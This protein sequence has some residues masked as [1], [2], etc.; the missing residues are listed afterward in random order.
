[1]AR[2]GSIGTQYFDNS[3]DPLINGELYFYE[4]GTTTDKP[5]YQD[6][7]QTVAHAQP[8]L[9]DAAGRQPNIFFDGAAKCV[10]ETS[11][12]VQIEVRDPVP[13][14]STAQDAFADWNALTDYDEGAL[15]K[16]SDDL[17]YKSI[18]AANLNN[19][20][21]TSSGY[22]QLVGFVNTYD[23]VQDYFVDQIAVDSGVLYVCIQDGTGQTPASSPT[24]WT[25][26]NI[27]ITGLTSDIGF[28]KADPAVLGN[29]TDGT[30]TVTAN[31]TSL[32]AMVKLYGDTH[33]TKAGDFEFLDDTTVVAH[34]DASGS[35]FDFQANA[36][37]TTGVITGGASIFA[38]GTT[39]GNL[40][41][42]DGSIVDSSGAI[43]FGDENLVTT[44]TLGSAAFTS[45]GLVTGS[46]FVGASGATITAFLDDDSF[47]T[48]SATT[49]ATS[50]SIKAYVDAQVGTA[51]TLAEVLAL[52]NTSGA[53]NLIIDSGQVITTNTI[54]ETTAASGV[55]I[56]SVLLKDNTVLAGTALLGA[57][58]LTDSSGA[59]SF[60]NENLS[61]TGTL[62]SG[63]LTVTGGMSATDD[64]SWGVP[65]TIFI[66]NGAE[67]VFNHPY[68]DSAR[69]II[70][71]LHTDDSAQPPRY[72]LCKNRGGP[73]SHQTVLDGDSLG[74]VQFFGDDGTNFVFA[75]MIDMSVSGTPSTGVVPTKMILQTATTAGAVV[76]GIEIDNAQNV[77]IPNGDLTVTAGSPS[78]I[79]STFA[80]GTTARAY[81]TLD[82]EST[83]GTPILTMT[84]AT[85][86]WINATTAS[87]TA[88]ALNIQTGGTTGLSIDLSQNVSIPNG[89]LTFDGS[90]YLDTWT[91]T[92]A[93]VVTMTAGSSGTITMN[94][95]A[96]TLGYELHGDLCHVQ[97][98]LAVSSV[99]SPVGDWRVSLPFTAANLAEGLGY[100][101]GTALAY[102]YASSLSGI[103]SILSGNGA[104]Y[105]NIVDQSSAGVVNSEA[106]H[107]GAGT[108]VYLDF[109]YRIA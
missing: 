58:S 63:A 6:I 74:E 14:A 105:F 13:N 9:L 78:T 96:D 87:N 107:V 50:E 65:Q 25:S 62:A 3:G 92:T 102:N 12:S 30:M 52:G 79:T 19:N 93:Y 69:N 43:S 15:V 51:D 31:T 8:V 56:D 99:S 24:Y 59:I 27:N 54:S 70:V 91:N 2:F 49:A 42:A 47:G 97:G 81:A 39:V 68:S 16:G 21:V 46:S 85:S 90:N 26:L 104:T 7:N 10:L 100:G 82:L 20:P 45:S 72:R 73:D 22:W 32:G 41:L 80:A 37:S 34:Y 98:W 55:T 75:G 106:N 5:V 88:T 4:S 83:T 94:T 23:A 66:G 95:G 35:L 64:S 101:T 84:G 61:T 103:S 44:G 33:A 11:A 67:W 71:H 17:Y 60:S 89:G 38:T 36:V 28:N 48:A 109:W 1:M 77:S 18:N 86:A 108:S 29:D 76:T 53:T 40:T 57:G